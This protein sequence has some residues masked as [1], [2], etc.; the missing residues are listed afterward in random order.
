MQ[1]RRTSRL[2]KTQLGMTLIELIC[3]FTILSLLAAM[4]VPLTRYKVRRDKERELRFALREIRTAIDRYKD[5]AA[6]N[7]F[8]VKVG[9]EGYPESLEMLVEGVNT[10]DAA[11]TKIKFLRRIPKDPMTNTSDWGM[12]SM[13]DDPKSQSWSGDNVFDVYTKSYERARD[14][15]PYSEW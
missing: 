9:T 1:V 12:R 7:K 14:G 6:Q 5:A 4:S 15:T 10:N 2:R 13:K 11:G 3:A 8:Q